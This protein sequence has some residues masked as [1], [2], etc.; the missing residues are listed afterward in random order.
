MAL[1]ELD[2]LKIRRYLSEKIQSV[3]DIGVVYEYDVVPKTSEEFESKFEYDGK[4]QAWTIRWGGI[5]R[6]DHRSNFLMH[7]EDYVIRTFFGFNEE[8][9]SDIT[10][11]KNLRTVYRMLSKDSTL[12]RLVANVEAVYAPDI[13][14]VRVGGVYS[15][16]TEITVEIK[17]FEE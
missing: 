10:F 8:Q 2:D 14:L 16:M 12:G 15:H 1:Q 6:P 7:T 4:I 13:A 17:G 9:R 11:G 5:G 3:K